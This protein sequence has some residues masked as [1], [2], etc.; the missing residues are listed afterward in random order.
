MWG[1]KLACNIDQRGRGVR[2]IGGVSMLVLGGVLLAAWAMPTGGA[3]AW[4]GSV[5]LLV[6]G[7]FCVFESRAGWCAV[8]AMGFKTRV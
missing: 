6:A 3:C 8:R 1:M 5:V 4:T 7:A 2:R